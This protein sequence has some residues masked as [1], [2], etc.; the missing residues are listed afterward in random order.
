MAI[1]LRMSAYDPKQTLNL[2]SI[3]GSVGCHFS[4]GA[5]S[6]SDG[7]NRAVV[8]QPLP[9]YNLTRARWALGIAIRFG[10]VSAA[11]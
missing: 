3:W 1:A 2:I 4:L 6:Q 10:L 7:E 9:R 8:A 11:A 5:R